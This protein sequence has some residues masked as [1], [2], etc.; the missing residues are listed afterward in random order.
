MIGNGEIGGVR[1][2]YLKIDILNSGSFDIPGNTS[3]PQKIEIPK[4]SV[5]M[6]L[7][8]AAA[9]FIFFTTSE[10][11]TKAEFDA[12]ETAGNAIYIIFDAQVGVSGL[13]GCNM[14]VRR[15]NN[16]SGIT[17]G[18]GCIIERVI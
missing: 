1:D 7:I 3:A 4:S 11:L 18:L 9:C 5:F 10:T 13:G 17:N 14:F 8:P 6:R 2:T 15:H 16:S 12:E